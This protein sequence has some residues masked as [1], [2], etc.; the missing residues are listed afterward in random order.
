[1]P[2]QRQLPG[3]HPRVKVVLPSGLFS[4]SAPCWRYS[5]PAV[6]AYRVLLSTHPGAPSP[7]QREKPCRNAG[8]AGPLTAIRCH[9]P[10]RRRRQAA[11]PERAKRAHD[12]RAQEKGRRT[13]FISKAVVLYCRSRSGANGNC[14]RA[15][16]ATA[17]RGQW[18]TDLAVRAAQARPI[19]GIP[20]RSIRVPAAV[21]DIYTASAREPGD[22]SICG[23]PIDGSSRPEAL[24]GSPG[25]TRLSG[26]AAERSVVSALAHAGRQERPSGS[27]HGLLQLHTHLVEREGAEVVRVLKVPDAIRDGVAP[28]MRRSRTR[29]FRANH[30]EQPSL[31]PPRQPVGR[32]HD[33]AIASSSPVRRTAASAGGTASPSERP[34]PVA[35]RSETRRLA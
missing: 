6:E 7:L 17:P 20:R 9:P 12:A 32:K 22:R 5:P 19:A 26:Q 2:P 10:R 14:G 25:R 30:A 16:R 13:S 18:P 1:M 11:Q 4:P 8:F 15:C 24:H 21:P 29:A 31:G 27:F 3:C 33:D 34:P 28:D 35:E 23:S